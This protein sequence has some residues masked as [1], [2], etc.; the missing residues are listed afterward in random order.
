[1]AGSAVSTTACWVCCC[2]W[3]TEC[4]DC[5]YGAVCAA[6]IISEEIK[7][8][9]GGLQTPTRHSGGEMSLSVQQG[10]DRVG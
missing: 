3:L 8:R 1:M 4:D 10:S 9:G 7:H 2:C 5:I 6:Y